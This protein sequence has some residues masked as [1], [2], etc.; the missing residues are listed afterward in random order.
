MFSTRSMFLIR[1]KANGPLA[2]NRPAVLLM[3]RV[4]SLDL[5]ASE[6]MGDIAG[7]CYPRVPGIFKN[8]PAENEAMSIPDCGPP[9]R[10]EWS[11]LLR[12]LIPSRQLDKQELLS[13]S[14]VVPLRTGRI[15]ISDEHKNRWKTN[16]EKHIDTV[17]ELLLLLF[18]HVVSYF[19]FLLL[20]L[21]PCV[22]STR[23]A[24]YR[25]WQF[26]AEMRYRVLRRT[27][28]SLCQG[29]QLIIS[30]ATKDLAS[31]RW[32]LA[33]GFLGAVRSWSDL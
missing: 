28:V 2:L 29:A 24:G 22:V 3:N 13:L 1:N 9:S 15:V 11:S 7:K 23:C 10:A 20:P 27:P 8:M 33:C 18:H 5:P 32:F 12:E 16:S 19:H 26:I 31:P 6:D 14:S 25:L 21:C 4:Y 30:D 17:N